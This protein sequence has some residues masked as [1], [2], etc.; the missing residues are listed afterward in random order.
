MNNKPNFEYFKERPIK[1][2]NL[3]NG[4][5][6]VL[7]FSWDGT[8]PPYKSPFEANHNIYRLNTQG[9]VV[10]QIQRDDSNHPSDWWE[11]LHSQAREKGWDGAY[12]PFT[13]VHLEYADGSTSFDEQTYKWRNPCEWRLGCKIWLVGSAYQQYVLDPETG[14][15][16]NVTDW[17]VRPW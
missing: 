15:A 1:R 4:D 14:I 17:P 5:R 11:I 7:T 13:E 10:W 2:V 8:E 9:E 6:I 12:E 3:P 16:K